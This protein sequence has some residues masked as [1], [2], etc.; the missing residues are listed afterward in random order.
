MREGVSIERERDLGFWVRERVRGS[1]ER[2]PFVRKSFNKKKFW[3]VEWLRLREVRIFCLECFFRGKRKFFVWEV[4][5]ICVEF[6]FCQIP[7]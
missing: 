2:E 7:I 3:V 4:I 1:I 6:C 5:P